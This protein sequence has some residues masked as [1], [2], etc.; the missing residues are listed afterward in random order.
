MKTLPSPFALFALAMFPAAAAFAQPIP[1]TTAPDIEKRVASIV[2]DWESLP[3]VFDDIDTSTA[4]IKELVEIGKPAVPALTAAL[5]RATRDTPMRL[6]PFTLRAI[7]DPRAVPALIRAIPKTLLPPGSDCGMSVRDP[8]LFKFMLTNDLNEAPGDRLARRNFDMGRPVRE[9]CGALRK[10]TGTNQN[11][12]AIFST[13]LDGGEQQRAMERKAF[14]EVARRWANWW[15][16]NYIQFVDDPTVAD[17]GLPA[18]KEESSLKR[19]LTGPNMKVSGGES[20]VIVTTVEKGSPDCCLALGLN[21]TLSLPKELSNTNGGAISIENVSA[22][23]A[24]TGADLLGTQ[25]RDPQSGKLYYCV[26]PL[27]LQAW[28]IPNH[29]WTNTEEVLQRNALPPLDAPAGDLLIHFDPVQK[30][31]APERRATF[32]FITRDGMQ[33][34]MR[35]MAQVT[36]PWSPR[37]MGRFAVAP[38]EN[39]PNQTE[40][41]GPFLGVKLDYKFFYAETDEMKAEREAREQLRA[42]RDTQRQSRKLAK[43]M[44]TYFHLSG[45]VYLPN[46]NAASNAAILLPV[47]TDTAILGDRKFEFESYSSIYRT[48]SNGSFVIPEI[49]GVHLL[50]VVHDEGF[51]EFKL[52]HP[53][54]PLSIRL[55]SWGRLEGVATLEGKPAPHE[56][57]ALLRGMLLPGERQLSLSPTAFQTESDDQG[58]FSFE[59]LPPGEL[60][61]CRMVGNTYR[62]AQ[63]VEIAADKTTII[64]HGYNG[65]LLTGRFVAS[66]ASS[67]LNWKGAQTFSLSTKM[68]PLEPPAGE[69][70]QTWQQKFWESAEGKQRQKDSLHFG[71]TMEGDGNFH[72]NDVPPGAYELRGDLREGGANDFAW[73]GKVLGRVN[74][75]V[76]VPER[77]ADKPN[78]PLDL[79]ELTVQMVINL[80]P[81]DTAPEFEVKN[82]DG[83]SLRLADFHGKYLLLDFWATWC[84]PCRAETPHLKS[85]YDSYG[86]NPNFAMLGLSLDKAVEEP[87]KYVKTEGIAWQQGFLGDWSKVT[88]P[89]RYGVE[90]IPAIF[91]VDPAGKIIAMD[92]RGEQIG[93]AVADALGKTEKASAK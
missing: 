52:D 39:E 61:V 2:S 20:G 27:G 84:G 45:T 8:E 62:Q 69:D 92:L 82:L 31:Y 51:C 87:K 75:D 15:K 56:K 83:G 28:E 64:R 71:L 86:K 91:L 66:D 14:D 23:A 79:G 68:L 21:R 85:V 59:H 25:Y 67:N 35:V 6:L 37:D 74:E 26:R 44:E 3:S 38:D 16:D 12:T 57:M 50:Y 18:L 36:R 77:S 65:R 55:L 72:I 11:D 5:D 73:G 49:P 88:L 58:R 1:A 34:M 33:G 54:S 43:Q 29:Y 22:W 4:Q 53:Q 63:F 70:P 13:F 76:L 90:G 7:G 41:A 32:L 40:D 24:R 48:A 93:K 78:E 46:G 89:A 80:K 30:R 10:I 81:G 19:F 60:Q 9:V 47:Q 17:V 42:S